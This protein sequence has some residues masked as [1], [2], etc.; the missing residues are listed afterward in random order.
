VLTVR[1]KITELAFRVFGRSLHPELFE[2]HLSRTIVRE[3]YRLKID[4]TSS[5]HLLTWQR[6]GMVFSE[7]AS[8]THQPLPARQQL[9]GDL[10]GAP[11]AQQ[12]QFCNTLDYSCQFQLD[13]AQPQTFAMIQKELLKSFP[14]EGMLFQF[15]S[16][17][18]ISM[19]A[20]SYVNI[21]SRRNT[22]HIR[23]F[24]TFPDAYVVMKSE[25]RFTIPDE[26]LLD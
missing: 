9:F 22:V 20:I 4:I 13:P 15:Q 23:A 26:A 24:H 19:G 3:Q 1:P 7:V 12:I 17:G 18:R 5:G 21:Q 25:S 2:T 11:S 8:S 16:S 10:V 6:H 14:C